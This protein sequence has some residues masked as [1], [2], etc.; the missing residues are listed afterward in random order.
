MFCASGGDS[1]GRAAVSSR[2][3][4]AQNSELGDGNAHVWRHG[5][6]DLNRHLPACSSD[7]AEDR[8]DGKRSAQCGFPAVRSSG[9]GAV[10]AGDELTTV[11]GRVVTNVLGAVVGSKNVAVAKTVDGWAVHASAIVLGWAAGGVRSVESGPPI[12]ARPEFRG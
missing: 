5:P 1:D 3:R 11:P 4:E 7:D 2:A 12:F 6:R 9:V 10:C 8:L